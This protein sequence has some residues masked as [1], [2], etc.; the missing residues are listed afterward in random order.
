MNTNTQLFRDNITNN[1]YYN[2]HWVSIKIISLIYHFWILVVHYLLKKNLS[3]HCENY[4]HC[5]SIKLM[6]FVIFNHLKDKK[7]LLECTLICASNNL[8]IF[9]DLNYSSK[10]HRRGPNQ[11]LLN[12]KSQ[13]LWHDVAKTHIRQNGTFWLNLHMRGCDMWTPKHMQN[14]LI[15]DS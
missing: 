2:F 13:S 7:Y 11:R 12:Q 14:N 5:C 10:K 8:K 15:W 1:I 6:F 4:M 3:A 9:S